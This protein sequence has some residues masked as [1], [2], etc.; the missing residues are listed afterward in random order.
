MLKPVC[1]DACPTITCSGGIAYPKQ[2]L[3]PEPHQVLNGASSLLREKMVRDVLKPLE[4]WLEAYKR[5][6]EDN[7]RVSFIRCREPRLYC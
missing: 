5:I 2:Y 4:Q 3:L 7:V 1:T 6:R